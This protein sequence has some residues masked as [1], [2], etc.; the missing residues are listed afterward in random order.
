MASLLNVNAV[1]NLLII[2]SELSSYKCYSNHCVQVLSSMPQYDLIAGM[3]E[4][5]MKFAYEDRYIWCV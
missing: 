1:H 5:A 4:K 3:L 2:V